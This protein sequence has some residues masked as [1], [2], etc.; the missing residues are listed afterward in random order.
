MPALDIF[1]ERRPNGSYAILNPANSKASALKPTQ[2][3]AIEEA[4]RMF[5]RALI[6]VERVRDTK[7]GTRD[8]WRLVYNGSK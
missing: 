7:V 4:K 8:K 5:P 6:Y 1:I 2:E 3:D